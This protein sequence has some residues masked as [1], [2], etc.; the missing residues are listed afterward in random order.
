[1]TKIILHETIT[2]SESGESESWEYPLTFKLTEKK[3]QLLLK[4]VLDPPEFGSLLLLP[5]C[6]LLL[7]S[8]SLQL[9]RPKPPHLAKRSWAPGCS[10]GLPPG[11]PWKAGPPTLLTTM[12][13]QSPDQV[14]QRYLHWR[15][16]IT[17]C[18]SPKNA[19]KDISS[20][21]K[22]QSIFDSQFEHKWPIWVVF[23]DQNARAPKLK[24]LEA[25]QNDFLSLG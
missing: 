7:T 11:P 25:P 23:G 6:P 3:R 16:L 14:E 1:M 15:I 4:I 22:G 12:G 10:Y 5:A 13:F 20:P 17:S 19:P 8:E 21:I 9:L 18:P 2:K 24:S